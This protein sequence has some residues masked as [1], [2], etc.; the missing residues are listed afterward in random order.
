MFTKFTKYHNLPILAQFIHKSALMLKYIVL[1]SFLSCSAH[2]QNE[3]HIKLFM[4][5]SSQERDSFFMQL[6]KEQKTYWLNR[7]VKEVGVDTM[8]GHTMEDVERA[9]H[10]ADLNHDGYPDVIDESNLG[11]SPVWI[12][13]SYPDTFRKIIDEAQS[14][15]K[16]IRYLGDKTEIIIQTMGM[17]DYFGGESIFI[18]SK[19]SV[20]LVKYR[21]RR[22]C[23]AAPQTY[24]KGPLSMQTI[25]SYVPIRENP[26]IGE[27]E[28]YQEDGRMKFDKEYD[29]K[30]NILERFKLNSKGLVWGETGDVYGNK[31]LFIE[32]LS[33]EKTEY[34]GYMVGWMKA[35]DVEII[36]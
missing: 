8:S 33:V 36:D 2:S 27:G 20:H 1:L 10:F 6:P 11:I 12:H 4:E 9:I 26:K 30:D 35:T 31:W 18:L 13:L 16:E 34:R 32:I 22:L 25:K 15:L 29:E 5:E 14:T 28:C 19:D 24:F 3:R 23:T 17:I 21:T 7:Y